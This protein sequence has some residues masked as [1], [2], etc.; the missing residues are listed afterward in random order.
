MVYDLHPTR[1]SHP[2]R[3]EI[4]SSPGITTASSRPLGDGFAL[5]RSLVTGSHRHPSGLLC[6]DRAQPLEGFFRSGKPPLF[7]HRTGPPPDL[8][9]RQQVTQVLTDLLAPGAYLD[10]QAVGHSLGRAEHPTQR[11]AGSPIP[12]NDRR[13]LEANHQLAAA[14]AGSGQGRPGSGRA[15]QLEKKASA[16][17]LK[18][19]YLDECGFTPTLPT[20][21][22]WSLPG[23]RKRID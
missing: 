17:R 14:Q 15:E 1:R 5:L 2:R 22:S 3:I 21:Y 13:R 10:Q 12:G 6:P 9:R 20:A 18:L 23:A 16:G 4:P 11:A 19:Y 7:P 8:Q